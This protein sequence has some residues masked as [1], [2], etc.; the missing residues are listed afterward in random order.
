MA[1]GWATW[2]AIQVKRDL[3]ATQGVASKVQRELA[4]GDVALAQSQLGGLADR[5]DEAAH[6]TDGPAWWLA[7]HIPVLG[8]NFGAVRRTALAAQL[9]GDTA[10]PAAT[11]AL[12]VAQRK[13]LLSDGQVDLAA[14]NELHGHVQRADRAAERAHSLVNQRSRWLLGPVGDGVDQ[15]R[16]KVGELAGTLDAAEQAL[17]IAPEMLGSEGRRRY[18]VAVQNNAEA[19]ATGGLVGAF[20]LV[21]TDRGR[22]VL[23]RTGT[24]TELPVLEQPVLSHPLAA[25]IWRRYGSGQVWYSANLTPNFPD[26]GRNLSRLW[27]AD[28]GGRIDGVLALDPLVISELLR[29]AG[30]VTLDDGLRI[31]ADSVVDFVG[32]DEY[33]RYPDVPSRKDVLSTLAAKIFERVLESGDSVRTLQAFARS[34]QSGHLFLWSRVPGEQRIL[35]QRLIG[36][37]LPDSNIPYLQVLT[38]NRGGNKL[39]FY[40][41][42]E[43]RIRPLGNDLIEVEITLRNNAPLGLPLY[44]TVRSD[45][46]DPPKPYGQARVGLA[47]Y[48]AWSSS[49]GEVRVDG[50]KTTMQIDRDH[51]H[52]LGFLD[53]ELPRSRP[54][55]VTMTM[56]QP[57]GVLTYRQQPLVVPDKLDVAV[58]YS[59]VGR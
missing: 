48:G 43:V 40:I 33:V 45:K 14:L 15:A 34:G 12:D 25:T 35:A 2:N 13:Q 24:D 17:D 29:V 7:E 9:L 51:G 47:V 58:P 41:R 42:R 46:P 55:R 22:I 37:A 50:V 21:T 57:P 30:P 32:H 10:L 8:G 52:P 1:F 16:D 5:L 39:D 38:Q 53:L 4:S 6:R 27:E 23:D 56:E 59:V 54:L 3:E 49:F 31:T 20:A 11:S 36:G 28:N 19:R 26:V 44:M 18:F